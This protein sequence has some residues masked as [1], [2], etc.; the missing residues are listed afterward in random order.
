LVVITPPAD[1]STPLNLLGPVP[2][3]SDGTSDHRS[4]QAAATQYLEDVY[5]AAGQAATIAAL[6]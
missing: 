4:I 5:R 6:S 3:P 2:L 1:G